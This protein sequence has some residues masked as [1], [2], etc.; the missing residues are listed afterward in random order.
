VNHSYFIQNQFPILKFIFDLLKF[1]HKK[2]KNLSFCADYQ[3][4]VDNELSS[5][6]HYHRYQLEFLIINNFSNMPLQ[7]KIDEYRDQFSEELT[8]LFD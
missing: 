7:R 6:F 1:T 3:L 5:I 8:E 2:V 4:K